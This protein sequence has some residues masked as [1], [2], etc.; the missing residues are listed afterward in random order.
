MNRADFQAWD[1]YFQVT[2]GFSELRRVDVRR[3]KEPEVVEMLSH[4]FGKLVMA[5]KQA[6][7]AMSS[8]TA[9]VAV[10][11]YQEIIGIGK[12]VVPLILAQLEREGDQPDMWFPALKAITHENPVSPGDQ[13]DMVAMAKAWIEW[14]QVN[15]VS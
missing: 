8:I 14:G 7:G 10:P 12:A 3:P 9:M 13:G 4:R 5:W 1:G 15:S 2:T 6:S 11:Q